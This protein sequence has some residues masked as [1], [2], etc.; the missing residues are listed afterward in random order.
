MTTP[1]TLFAQILPIFTNQTERVATEALRHILLQSEPAR[2][3]LQSTLLSAGVT[4]GPLTRFQTEASGDG[5]ERVDLV[6]G[7]E[8]QVERVLIEAKFWA[9]LTDNQ[10]NAYLARLPQTG[11]AALLFIAPAERMETLWPELC[12]RA[13]QAYQTAA[14][15]ET[16]DFRSADI[17]GSARKM[18]MTSWRALLEQMEAR[19]SAAG[20]AAAM[21]DIRQLRGLTELM[22]ADAFL[23]LHSD[24]LGPEFPRRMLNLVR[25]VDDATQRAMANDWADARG[26]RITPQWHGYGRYFRLH[27]VV[28]WFG[29]NFQHWAGGSQTPLWLQSQQDSLWEPVFLPTGVEYADVLDLVVSQLDI[30]GQQLNPER[31]NQ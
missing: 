18:M 12:G 7:D 30:I 28:V 15:V 2:Q 20:D 22:D 17:D 21:A 4:T 5:G 8:N 23:P 26:L 9:G 6:C 16:G 25:L 13:Q 3:A 19:A 29:I 11:P 14:L 1:T 24:E 31:S 27:G 10:P